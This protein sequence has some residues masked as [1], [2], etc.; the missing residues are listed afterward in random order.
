MGLT[1]KTLVGRAMKGNVDWT[2]LS[3]TMRLEG[4]EK[5]VILEWVEE[6]ELN[7]VSYTEPV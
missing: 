1:S 7:T 3:G 5:S 2:V 6:T 4:E